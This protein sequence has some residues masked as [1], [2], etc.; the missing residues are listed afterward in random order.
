MKPGD[1]V[2]TIGRINSGII[3]GSVF[4]STPDEILPYL[5]DGLARVTG[6]LA[7]GKQTVDRLKAMFADRSDGVDSINRFAEDNQGELY[8]EKPGRIRFAFRPPNP[9]TIVATGDGLASVTASALSLPACTCG[10]KATAVPKAT[11]TRPAT[12]SSVIGASPL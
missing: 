5:A 2:I 3:V 7:D 8:I 6:W 1:D 10:R 9:M 12:R 11:C 4:G